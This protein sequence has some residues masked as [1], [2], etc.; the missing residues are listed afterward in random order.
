LSNASSLAAASSLRADLRTALAQ[1]EAYPVERTWRPAFLTPLSALPHPQRAAL[2]DLTGK[3]PMVAPFGGQPLT[4]GS[5]LAGLRTRTLTAADLLQ[6]V[7]AAIGRSAQDPNAL[8]F[9]P[10]AAEL[11]AEAEAL[12]AELR[13]GVCR[14]LLHGIPLLT[15]DRL[16]VAGMPASADAHALDSRPACSDAG[17]VRLLRAAGALFVAQTRTNGPARNGASSARRG[18]AGDGGKEDG[19]SGAAAAVARGMSMGAPVPDAC[20]SLHGTAARYG[21]VS[22]KPTFGLI[23]NDGAHMSSWSIDQVG[24]LALTVEDAALLLDVLDPAPHMRYSQALFKALRG[25]HIGL[26]LALLERAEAGAAAAVRAA[27]AA[28]RRA[29]AEIA[30]IETPGAED[31]ELAQAAALVLRR[32]EAA[33]YWAFAGRLRT[34]DSAPAPAPVGARPVAR[35]AEEAGR[36]SAAHYLQAQRIREDLRWRLLRLFDRCDALLLPPGRADAEGFGPAQSLAQNSVLWSLLGF[37]TVS[38]PCGWTPQQA[39]I[40]AE[41]VAAPYADTRLLSIAAALELEL[42]G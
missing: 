23:P 22:Y 1:I 31:V 15:P 18:R 21:L 4:I 6:A 36:V 33:A 26:P 40:G 25:V 42:R 34:Q 16:D 5:A 20:G 12:D 29:G 19:A 14:G 11:R 37:P 17:S 30:E 35:L 9:I 27:A 38:L 7:L 41:L 2:A 3:R 24:C 10:P 39:P 13:A 32:A 28:M 8:L